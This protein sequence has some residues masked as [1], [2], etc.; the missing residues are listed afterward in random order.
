MVRFSHANNGI[1]PSVIPR[2]RM[3]RMVAKILTAVPILPTPET[4]RDRV[5]KSALCPGENVLDVSG[6]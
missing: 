2:Q 4:I 6:A 5:Q 1:F 3:Q